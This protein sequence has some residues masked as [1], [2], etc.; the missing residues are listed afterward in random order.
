MYN[1]CDD[2]EFLT[3]LEKDH[4]NSGGTLPSR[5]GTERFLQELL[6]LI[7]PQLATED[8]Y[9]T[10]AEVAAELVRLERALTRLLV[11]LSA[12]PGAA[13]RRFM[14]E[15]PGVRTLLQEDALAIERGDPAAHSLDEVIAAY[16]GFY[17]I[18]A[19][20]VAHAL[21]A[22]GVRILPRLITEY[23]HR[24]TGVDIHPGAQIGHSFCID[25]ATGVVIGETTEIGDG[26]KIY[27]GVT[28]GA[29]SVAKDLQNTRR[30]PRVGDG[31][32]I[33]ANATI[34]GGATVI[35]E[36][37]V[38]GGGAWVTFSVPPRSIV[39]NRA[40]IHVRGEDEGIIFHI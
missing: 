37:S 23:A 5:T 9:R 3:E 36:Q 25:H 15:L 17:A 22:P 21:Y 38:I 11:P 33:Y 34:L 31:V 32:V 12:D 6:G 18:A 8:R 4:Q 29:L 27:Q 26:V 14:S 1:P 13:A 35:G 28:L 2:D 39:Y 10:G 24:L 7:F 40:E 20:R 19:Y 30:H 16:P